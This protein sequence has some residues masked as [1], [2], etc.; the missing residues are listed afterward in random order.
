MV[1][2][3]HP[4]DRAHP[5]EAVEHHRE[6]RPVPAKVPVS[7]VSELPR[8]GRRQDRHRALG[9]DVL[10]AAHG[11]GGVRPQDL[12]DDEPVAE[13]AD[14]GQVLLHGRTR[15]GLARATSSGRKLGRPK[16]S[17]GVSQLDGKEDEIRRFL[18]LG[19][20]KTAIAKITHELDETRSRTSHGRCAACSC[21][22]RG[23]SRGAV[24]R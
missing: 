21:T 5:R 18:E 24:S 10:R 22:I 15:E 20:S 23:R 6:E 14:R 4:Q 17:L 16:G 2:P 3:P 8:L 13:H 1:L 12:A 7:I 19:V 11:R 9:D